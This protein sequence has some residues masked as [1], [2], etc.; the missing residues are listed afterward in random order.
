MQY[1]EIN[2]P[3]YC[4]SFNTCHEESKWNAYGVVWHNI[5][6]D[7]NHLIVPNRWKLWVK[8]KY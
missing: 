2:M 8:T 6:F 4:D 5:R 3:L 7:Q 1:C